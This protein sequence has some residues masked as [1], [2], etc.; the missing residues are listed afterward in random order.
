MKPKYFN[1]L[2]KEILLFV[3]TQVLG[4]F[5]TL[6]LLK[7]L[8][9]LEIKLQPISLSSF[10]IYFL[11]VTLLI[12]ALLKISRGKAG[13]LLQILFILAVFFGL[14]ILF[15]TFIV[16]PGAV[17]LAAGLIVLRFLQPTVLLHNLV[18]IGGLAGIGGMLGLSLSPRDV[19]ILLVI[20]SIY[21]VIAVYKTKH[22]TKMAKEMIKKRVILGIIVPEKI[23]EFKAS[24]TE[25]EKDKTSI[26][27]V[28]KLNKASRFTILGGGDLAL[29]LL[30]ITSVAHQ[31]IWR[32]IIVLVFALLGLILMHLIFI[33]LKRQPI[34]ALPPLAV[35]SILGY[36][37]SLLI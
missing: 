1:L 12:L 15:S 7:L 16:E 35:F 10:L 5:V 3:L 32:S 22:M 27:K 17:I 18:V 34:P 11:I 9:V 26:T 19:V 13:F 31:N 8:E 2:W 23:S 37:I 25:V 36:L 14:D 30:L 21:D 20:L 28:P 33:K 4:I 6:R 29:P 24:M